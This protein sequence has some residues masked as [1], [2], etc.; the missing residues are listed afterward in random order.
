M[1]IDFDWQAGNE[2]GGWDVLA[3]QARRRR[4]RRMRWVPLVAVVLL[5]AAAIGGYVALRRRYARA[6]QQ[7]IFQIQSVIDLEATAYAR[8]DA[9]LYLA[10][11]DV[12]SP[13]WYALQQDRIGADCAGTASAPSLEPQC[14]PVLEAQIQ[15]VD[16][17]G[18]VAWV[19]V[20]EGDPPMR[21]ARFYRQTA[22][23]WAHTAPRVSFWGH[24]IELHYGELIARYH[25]RDQP[26][27]D[28]LVERIAQAYYDTCAR[29]ECEED[30][31]IVDFAVDAR[32]AAGVVPPLSGQ[33]W[34]IPSPWLSGLPADGDWPKVQLDSLAYLV[35]QGLAEQRTQ[36]SR[37]RSDRWLPEV[38]VVG[39]TTGQ[40]TRIIVAGP[41]LDDST[42]VTGPIPLSNDHAFIAGRA[43]RALIGYTN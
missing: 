34:T 4:S 40:P 24:A 16:L 42:I 41:V 5:T 35:T 43:A 39:H 10:Q 15:Q 28:P 32:L 12:S 25:D 8:G 26:H 29:I 23:G 22:L 3:E 7:M 36:D 33:E 30:A 19:E 6:Y 20:I 37:S 38:M 9:E 18:D 31:L 2:Q 27:V 11:Q 1:G 21:R 14:A 17:R 13:D